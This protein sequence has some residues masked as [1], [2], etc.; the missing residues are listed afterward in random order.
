MLDQL[1][2]AVQEVR[3]GQRRR[4]QE[5]RYSLATAPV[6]VCGTYLEQA[7]HALKERY[8]PPEWTPGFLL[9]S[10]ATLACDAVGVV[11]GAAFVVGVG[12]GLAVLSRLKGNDFEPRR[13]E[14]RDVIAWSSVIGVISLVVVEVLGTTAYERAPLSLSLRLVVA[15]LL[16]ACAISTA[17]IAVIFMIVFTNLAIL[18]WGKMYWPTSDDGRQHREVEKASQ[19][20]PDGL[21]G[22]ERNDQA[23]TPQRQQDS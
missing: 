3:Q 13:P 18:T 20:R 6:T 7:S 17:L 21:A 8:E 12:C 16:V 1:Q 15:P 11:I 23:A 14:R 5:L 2:Q 22:Q 9:S 10:T 4:L 19:V